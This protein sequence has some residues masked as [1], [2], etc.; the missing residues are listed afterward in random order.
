MI[1]TNLLL[2]GA[3]TANKQV[4]CQGLRCSRAGSSRARDGPTGPWDSVMQPH[5][6]SSAMVPSVRRVPQS[7]GLVSWKRAGKGCRRAC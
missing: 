4:W 7:G 5:V 2:E 6:A 1:L 3:T